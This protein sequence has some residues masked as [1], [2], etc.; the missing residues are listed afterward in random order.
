[1]SIAR[2]Q[3][4]KLFLFDVDGVAT[5]G[6][7]WVFPIPNGS[8]DGDTQTAIEPK[9]FHAH[10]GIGV[11][12]AKLAGLKMGSSPSVFRRRWPSARVLCILTTFCRAFPTSARRL[13]KS[14]PKRG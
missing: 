12:L 7:I 5:D 9:G 3:K 6:K 10:D 14:L 2:A 4:I 1:M 8:A 11:S 13:N